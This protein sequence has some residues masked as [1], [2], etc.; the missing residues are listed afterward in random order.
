[1]DRACPR[2]GTPLP[3]D[4]NPRRRY[5]SGACRRAAHETRVRARYRETRDDFAGFVARHGSPAER[6]A[7]AAIMAD[8]DLADV[9]VRALLAGAA[10]ADGE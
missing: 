7:F 10:V 4:A 1:M 2:C 6:A 3:L 8:P 9:M 5:C